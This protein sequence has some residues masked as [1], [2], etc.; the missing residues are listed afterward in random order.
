MGPKVGTIGLALMVVGVIAASSVMILWFAVRIDGF[1]F[2]NRTVGALS[3]LFGN[4][5]WSV[6]VVAHDWFVTQAKLRFFERVGLPKVVA[7][8]PQ[9]SVSIVT[10]AFIMLM[11]LLYLANYAL[12][13]KGSI[14][15]AA[16]LGGYRHYFSVFWPCRRSTF[17]STIYGSTTPK[18]GQ[19]FFLES[20]RR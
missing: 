9:F 5:G 19:P 6:G 12:I 18:V 2:S 3:F 13:K 14:K 16:T 7:K 15:R 1:R 17:I 10:I 20:M 4:I 8:S 11:G